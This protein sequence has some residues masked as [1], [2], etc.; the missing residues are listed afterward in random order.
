M[1]HCPSLAG[2]LAEN[3]LKAWLSADAVRVQTELER[4]IAVPVQARD[5]GEQERRQLLQSVA[6]RMRKCPDLLEPR[7]QSPEL[8]LYAHLLFSLSFG[9]LE[10]WSQ[11]PN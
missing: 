4:S 9:A 3:L 7:S 11:G 5:T 10:P 1:R 8:N 6:S 2:R